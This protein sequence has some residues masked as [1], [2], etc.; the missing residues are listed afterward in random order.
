[1]AAPFF[2]D[3]AQGL[4]VNGRMGVQ[5][6]RIRS[7]ERKRG[8]WRS[9]RQQFVLGRHMR[10][11]ASWTYIAISPCETMVKIGW[12]RSPAERIF[13]G[14]DIRRFEKTHGIGRVALVRAYP[15]NVERE[16]LAFMAPDRASTEHREWFHAGPRFRVL[17]GRLDRR[18]R[19]QY[20]AKIHPPSIPH[21]E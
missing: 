5:R 4:P 19:G 7:E 14:A 12:S 10:W 20:G 17:L 21:R 9:M 11:C 15:E 8:A 16:C 13:Y 3:L 18:F 6:R 1:M 2:C